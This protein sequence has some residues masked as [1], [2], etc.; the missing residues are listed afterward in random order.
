MTANTNNAERLIDFVYYENQLLDEGRY[1]EWY[2]LFDDDGVY[3][4]PTSPDQTDKEG[5]A[6]IALESKL[7]LKLRITRLHHERAHSLQ[8]TVKGLHVVQRPVV[9]QPENGFESVSCN[10]A[11]FEYQNGS[12][13]TLGAKVRYLIRAQAD[14]LHIVEKRV[15]L[16]G[17]DGFLPAIQLFI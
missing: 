8:P 2:D 13:V 12:Q 14:A 11:Y 15:A 3:W 4:V 5:Q 10:L 17:C 6:S 9:G 1:D 7:L 16:L